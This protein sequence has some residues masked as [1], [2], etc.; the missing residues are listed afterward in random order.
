MKYRNRSPR[1][2]HGFAR[3]I[4]RCPTCDAS[5]YSHYSHSS[6][7]GTEQTD[8]YRTPRARGRCPDVPESRS[9]YGYQSPRRIGG[10]H[11]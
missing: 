5:S 7:L 9:A 4:V 1:C 8:E 6:H 2:R 3:D 10:S 11:G